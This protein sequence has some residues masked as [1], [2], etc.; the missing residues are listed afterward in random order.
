MNMYSIHIYMSQ[1]DNADVSRRDKFQQL[2]QRWWRPNINSCESPSDGL[3]IDHLSLRRW[4]FLET[5]HPS[6]VSQKLKQDTLQWR[7]SVLER[8]GTIRFLKLPDNRSHYNEKNIAFKCV[9]YGYLKNKTLCIT[10]SENKT[11]AQL[12]QWWSACVSGNM[13]CGSTLPPCGE[14]RVILSWVVWSDDLSGRETHRMGF[15]IALC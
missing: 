9:W 11:R 15:S 2:S 8:T 7:V 5:S 14:A 12:A 4:Y 1:I 6:S 10:T 13:G 3:L